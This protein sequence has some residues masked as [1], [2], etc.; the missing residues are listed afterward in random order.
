MN[1][2][3]FMRDI[4]EVRQIIR[5]QSQKVQIIRKF[6]VREGEMMM[7]AE[8]GRMPFED[9]RRGVIFREYKSSSP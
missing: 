1:Y 4:G 3:I 6:G 2:N 7:E 9:R 8:R 5:V